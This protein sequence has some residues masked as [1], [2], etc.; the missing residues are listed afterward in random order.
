MCCGRSVWISGRLLE[1][2]WC[3]FLESLESPLKQ[4][5]MCKTQTHLAA[6]CAVYEFA[7]HLWHH[8]SDAPSASPPCRSVRAASASPL[9]WGTRFRNPVA[10]WNWYNR[11]VKV[12]HSVPSGSKRTGTTNMSIQPDRIYR[13]H[14]KS[15]KFCIKAKYAVWI[16]VC[17]RRIYRR[18]LGF[19]QQIIT[20]FE[21]ALFQWQT[22][23]VNNTSCFYVNL[24]SQMWNLPIAFTMYL[25]TAHSCIWTERQVIQI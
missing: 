2:H 13:F 12:L 21:E 23:L 14:L 11:L 9:A 19:H 18:N 4:H 15:Q 25:N 24:F 5:N 1:N 10:W 16:A 17:L 22:K 8:E 3:I 20:T 7:L 6:A